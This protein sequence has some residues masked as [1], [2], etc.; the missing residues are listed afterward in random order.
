VSSFF[1]FLLSVGDHRVWIQQLLEK[2][3]DHT[4]RKKATVSTHN[5]GPVGITLSMDVIEDTLALGP[6]VTCFLGILLHGQD[7]HRIKRAIGEFNSDY[8]IFS[9]IGAHVQDDISPR[10]RRYQKNKL[11]GL[12]ELGHGQSNDATQRRL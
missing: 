6:Y 8:Q 12:E 2:T 5:L 11:R 9:D 7:I 10:A 3:R 4:S 1:P